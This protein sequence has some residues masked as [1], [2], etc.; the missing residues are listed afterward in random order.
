MFDHIKSKDLKLHKY[1]YT[2]INQTGSVRYT[3]Q[4]INY[5]MY[6]VNANFVLINNYIF[7]P[8]NQQL[9]VFKL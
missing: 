8:K 2:S 5:S 7:I 9:T 3:I 6:D 4:N 1:T